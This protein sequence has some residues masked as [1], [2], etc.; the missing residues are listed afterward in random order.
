MYTLLEM[1]MMTDQ[2]QDT[3]PNYQSRIHKLTEHLYRKNA[4]IAEF[5]ECS[6]EMKQN[7]LKLLQQFAEEVIA[8]KVDGDKYAEMDYDFLDWMNTLR[9]SQRTRAKSLLG[10]E[11]NE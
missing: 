9:E 8:T 7:I 3:S 5:H 10:G 6:E 1:K 2:T 11:S 4:V